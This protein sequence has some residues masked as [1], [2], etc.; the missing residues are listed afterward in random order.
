VTDKIGYVFSWIG[1]LY[2]VLGYILYTES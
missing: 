1:I 2:P